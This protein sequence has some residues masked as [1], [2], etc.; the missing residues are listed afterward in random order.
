MT[1]VPV[2]TAVLLHGFGT[3]GRLWDAAV[4]LLGGPAL[5]LDLP[6]FGDSRGGRYSVGGMVDAVQEQLAGLESFVLVGHSMGAK[7]AAVLAGRRPAGLRALLLIAPSPPSPEPMSDQ[8]R[9][10]LKAAHGQPERLRQHYEKITR[11]PLSEQMMTQLI[12][13]GLRAGPA[14]WNAWPDSG[15]RENVG[16]RVADITVP[17]TLL[18]SV[19]DPVITPQVVAEQLGHAFPQAAFKQ[20][21]GSGHLLPLELPAEVA[22]AVRAVCA[23][24]SAWP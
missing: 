14:A 1:A 13:D 7:V 18:T 10:D 12:S 5:A 11:L 9:T 21:Q 8:D 4:P 15:S 22:A 3:S 2:A 23:E 6:G 24:S 16:A 17:V 20:V 19:A